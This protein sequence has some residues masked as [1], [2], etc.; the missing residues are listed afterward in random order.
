MAAVCV[1]GSKNIMN[2]A[3]ICPKGGM[4]SFDDSNNCI[5]NKLRSFQ[6]PRLYWMTHI[7]NNNW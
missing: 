5:N 4:Y 6:S 7:H 1:C 3:L 2:H